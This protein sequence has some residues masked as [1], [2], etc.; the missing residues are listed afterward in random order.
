[1]MAILVGSS[2]IR[3][4]MDVE[5]RPAWLTWVVGSTPSASRPKPGTRTG[6]SEVF[7]FGH[8]EQGLI[9]AEDKI[10]RAVRLLAAAR[11]AEARAMTSLRDVT[12]I[13]ARRPGDE[14][15]TAST[16]TLW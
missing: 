16:G 3:V 14:E 7:P 11:D 8:E 10:E 15:E 1:M 13:Q 6:L 12:R 9:T 4:P 5:Y 2:A